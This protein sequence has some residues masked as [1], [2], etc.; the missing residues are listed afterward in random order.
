MMISGIFTS[1]LAI[2]VINYLQLLPQEGKLRS[3]EMHSSIQHL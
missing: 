1:L 3:M 2:F